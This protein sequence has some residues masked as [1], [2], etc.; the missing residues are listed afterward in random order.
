MRHTRA[1]AIAFVVVL[2]ASPVAQ[3]VDALLRQA[4]T[5]LESGK[6]TDAK[7]AFERALEA[8]RRLALEPQQ[9]AALCGIGEALM[10]DTQYRGGREFVLQCLELYER[11]ALPAGIGRANLLLNFGAEYSGELP[12]ARSRA[13]LAIAAFESAGDRAGRAAATLNLLRAG[14]L[15]P[16]EADRLRARAIEDARATGSR[17]LEASALH[18]WGDVLFSVSRYEEAFEKLEQAASLYE[19]IGNRVDLGTVFNSLGRLYRAHGRLDEALQFQLKALELHQAAGA[20]LPQMQSLNA[21]AVVHGL[22]GHPKEASE[23]YERALAIAERSSSPR[24]QDFLRANIAAQLGDQG[25]F[26]RGAR[27]LE[28][29]IAHGV[30]SYPSV[31]HSQLAYARVKLGQAR[32]GLAAAEQAVALCGSASSDCIFALRTRALAHAAL[33]DYV[34]AF[35]DVTSALNRLEDVRKQLVPADFFR[36]EF[37]RAQQWVYSE[38][39]ALRLSQQQ[40]ARALETAELARSR[41]FLD[42]LASRAAGLGSAVAATPATATD[43]AATASRIGSTFVLYWVAQD[44]VVIWV[45]TPDGGVRARRVK[46]LRSRLE[47][48]VRATSPF[49]KLQNA[50]AP[51]ASTRAWRDLYDL[52]IQPVRDALPRARGS[53]LTIVPHGPLLNLSFAALEDPRG[54]Y[55]LED[56]TVH[57]APAASLLQFTSGARPPAGRTGNMLFVADP[58]LPIRSR[59]DQPLGRLPGARAE[60]AAIER[61][62]PRLRATVLQDGRATEAAVRAA[63][64][65]KAVLHFA[66]HAIVRDDDPLASFLAVGPSA[67]GAETDGLLT[68]QEVYGWSLNADLIV[69]SACRSA[70]GRITGDGV[71]ALARAFMYA[72]TPSLVASLWDVA[73]EPTNRLLPGFYRAWLGGQSK[74]RALR[75]AQLQLLADLRAGKVQIQTPAGLITVP[76]HPAYWAGF[77]LIGEPG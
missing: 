64:G 37:H 18:S 14:G 54:R 12:E 59:L 28:E 34:A 4:A 61:L 26:A 40:D 62:V 9:A 56:Y 23:F 41:A 20:P 76:E 24:I 10:R 2:A 69:L 50:P 73:D 57:Y 17:Q 39:I 38:A 30:D 1:L 32:E 74:A 53:L 63:V 71:A 11:L 72:G 8:A 55:L 44:E 42:L 65:G 58:A 6:T 35:A 45:V 46:V 21:V 66:T 51:S 19:A 16:A 36:Q 49:T 47:D 22:M 13:R 33:G 48:L 60:V 67:G 43:M 15:E 75:T 27:M 3:D 68:A 7:A 70:G 5:L 52:L 31:R 29:V 25:E 77:A